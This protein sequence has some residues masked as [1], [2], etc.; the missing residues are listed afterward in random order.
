MSGLVGS[1]IAVA[2][3]AGNPR[4][5]PGVAE[6]TIFVVPAP[7]GALQNITS[8]VPTPPGTLQN[9]FLNSSGA[10]WSLP[11]HYFA[12]PAPPGAV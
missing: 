12:I 8:A 6:T 9:N 2:G 5:L 4:S 10:S 1:W 3:H 7:P 11:E